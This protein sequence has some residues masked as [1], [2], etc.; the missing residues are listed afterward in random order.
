MSNSRVTLVDITDRV[1][2]IYDTNEGWVVKKMSLEYVNII[3]DILPI[4]YQKDM[5]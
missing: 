1:P 3:I 4:I 5:I 2:N